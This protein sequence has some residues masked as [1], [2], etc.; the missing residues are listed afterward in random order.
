M[1]HTMSRDVARLHLI[2]YIV[3]GF[4]ALLALFPFAMLA[5]NSFASEHAI[6][7]YGYSFAP[8]ELS[9]SAY[10]M[11]F[12]NPQKMLRTYALTIF[13]T[14][15]GT[16]VSLFFSTMAAFVLSRRELRYRNALAFFLYFTQLF[17]GGLVPYYILLSKGLHLQNSVL[18]LILVPMF[19]VLNILILRNYIGN[20]IPVS[21]FE[22]AKMDGANELALYLRIALPISKPAL[23]SIGLLTALGYWND[24]WTPMMF[25]QR[26]SMYPLQYTLYQLL[27]SINF[28]AAMVN[29]LP[30]INMPK[31]SLKLA[32][33]VVATGPIILVYPFVQRY[34]VKGIILGAVKG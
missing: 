17:N 21:L 29:S 23:A 22:S 33:T 7:N 34:F 13:I 18:V 24:W 30:V 10:R 15:T 6:I 28:A 14:V 1:S 27:S 26:E 8:K 16:G 9:L 20:S 25:I 32:M 12:Q 5:I 3:V 2:A 11:I 19:S 31:E 4:F